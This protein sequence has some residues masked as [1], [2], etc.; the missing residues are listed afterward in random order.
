MGVVHGDDI[1]LAGPRSPVDAVRKSLRKRYEKR[2][3][4]MGVR[5]TDASEIV[6]LNRRVQWTE[7]RNSNLT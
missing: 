4:M 3:Q 7:E 1:L 2:E 5:P 6:M